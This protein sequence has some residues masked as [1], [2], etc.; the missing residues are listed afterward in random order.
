MSMELLIFCIKGVFFFM[1]YSDKLVNLLYL[2]MKVYCE[3]ISKCKKVDD[4]YVVIVRLE[5]IVGVYFDE[6]LGI[7]ILGVNFDVMFLVGVKL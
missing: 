2:V 3:L 7:Y 4:D 5:F 6:I 1:M